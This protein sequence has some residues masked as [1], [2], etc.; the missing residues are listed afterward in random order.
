[1]SRQPDLPQEFL[2]LLKTIRGK[3]ARIVIEH[4]LEHGFITT[5][6]LE[7]RYGYK[8]PPRAIRDVRE[9]GIPIETYSIK[10]TEGKTIA[11]YRLGEFAGVVTGRIGGRRSYPRSLKKLLLDGTG[12]KCAVC[13]QSYQVRYLQIDH[14]VPYEVAGDTGLDYDPEEFMLLCG[15]CNRAKSWSCEHCTNWRITKDPDICKSCYW[16]SPNS[17]NHIALQ[18]IRRIDLVWYESEVIDYDR[19]KAHAPDHELAEFIKSILRKFI[20][21]DAE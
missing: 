20:Q 19:L 1:M 21:D 4:I 17:Y 2:E 8:H 10:T 7:Q 14:R 3:R 18:S 13:S 12:S 11:A 5:E 9:Q 6:D 16:G 15:S